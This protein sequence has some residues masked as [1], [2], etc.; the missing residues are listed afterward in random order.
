M[1]SHGRPVDQTL[2]SPREQFRWMQVP[3][4][5]SSELENRSTV[6]QKPLDKHLR[7]QTPQ[8]H[9]QQHHDQHH[10]SPS[11]MF[12]RLFWAGRPPE[13]L[14]VSGC[15]PSGQQHGGTG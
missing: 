12:H 2:G 3:G 15:S 6:S 7:T 1:L 8:H 14:K 13:P 10:T 11:V 9:H 5:I 4:S